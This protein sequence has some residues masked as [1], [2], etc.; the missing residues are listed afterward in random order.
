[1]KLKEILVRIFDYNRN[2]K[3]EFKEFVYGMIFM[4]LYWGIIIGLI[5]IM[6]KLLD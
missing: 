2:G 1:M 5:I 4:S 3:V 6:V